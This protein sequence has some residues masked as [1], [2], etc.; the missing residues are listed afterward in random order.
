MDLIKILSNSTR[1]QVLQYLQMHGAATTKQISDYLPDVPVPTLYRHIN[2]LIG[3]GIVQVTEERKIRGSVER[4]LAINAEKLNESGD[5]SDVAYQ[6]L[7]EIYTRFYRYSRKSDPDPVKDKLA[8]RTATL[9]LTDKEM[10][11]MLNELATVFAKYEALS[12][13]SKGK[14]RSI[15]TISAPVEE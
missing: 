3:E 4:V 1:M 2:Y 15:S 7:M 6:F 9:K 12:Q 14:L 5:I 10:E 13:Q 11:D 8:L